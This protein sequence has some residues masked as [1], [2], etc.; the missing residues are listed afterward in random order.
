MA[1]VSPTDK[2]FTILGLGSLLSERSARLTLPELTNFRLARVSGYRRI[3]AHTPAMF[4][5]RGIANAE[6]LEMSSL[7]AE[8]HEG[9]SFVVT[10]FDVPDDGT[11]MEAFRAREEAFELRM[12]PFESVSGETGAGMGMLCVRS[13]TDAYINNWGQE[14]F[15]SEYASRGLTK[16]WEWPEDSGLRPCAA[17]LRHC[18]LAAQK[19]PDVARDSF[20]DDTF[21][22]DRRTTVRAYLAA[23]PKVLTTL[24][25]EELRERYG[26]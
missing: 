15:D 9:G 6:T 7:S 2:V 19:L 22:C 18:V 25:P 3:F 16:I 5:Q 1:P 23:H 17:Y 10:A 11:G 8:P 13:T 4:M 20:L 24:P 26:G 21:L 14:R 12:V